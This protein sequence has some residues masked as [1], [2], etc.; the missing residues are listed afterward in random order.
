M[1]EI[2][3][4]RRQ[5]IRSTIGGAVL[6]GCGMNDAK[7]QDN[8]SQ[9][10]KYGVASGDPKPDGVV[11]WTAIDKNAYLPG[12]ELQVEIAENPAMQINKRTIAVQDFS[13]ERDYTAQIDVDGMAPDRL[14]YYRFS[15][16][17][18]HSRVGRCR[19][20]P[21]PHQNRR[22]L[23]LAVLTCQDYTTGY[24]SAYRHLAQNDDVDFAIHVGDFIYEYEE[25]PG[26]AD[27][28]V[29]RPGLS[30]KFALGLEDYR[31]IF[32]A[33]RLDPDLQNA[34]AKHTFMITIDDHEIGDNVHFN[35]RNNVR[36]VGYYDSDPHPYAVNPKDNPEFTP[37]QKQILKRLVAEAMQ[38]WQEYVP[39]RI[40]G[41]T[42]FR[43]NDT[44]ILYRDF[45]FGTLAHIYLTDSRS[46]RNRESCV[47]GGMFYNNFQ[48]WES[49]NKDRT[50]LGATQAKW[51]KDG[52]IATN[53]TWRIWG[54]QTLLS[55][56]AIRRPKI[57][58]FSRKK[59]NLQFYLNQDAWDGYQHERVNLLTSFY[60]AGIRDLVVLTGDMHV[61]LTSKVVLDYDLVAEDQ[62][63]VG[64]EFMT[65]AVSSPHMKDAL[66]TATSEYQ[67]LKDKLG[68]D[69]SNVSEMLL[70]HNTHFESLTPDINGYAV[71]ELTPETLTWKVYGFDKLQPNRGV[72]STSTAT[73][74]RTT[75]DGKTHLVK[76]S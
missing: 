8:G 64:L 47:D 43:G 51:L 62:Q 74:N 45:K 72:T 71:C 50:M 37:E 63:Q 16:N 67:W 9:I 2:R 75:K 5:V 11:L 56:C 42:D 21:A 60:D 54:N 28:I 41:R 12:L 73:Y 65:P 32:K 57:N 46:Y 24:F 6:A 4:T 69:I 59:G 61:G 39:A 23:N 26:F 55:E 20:L 38:A 27:A 44:P 1:A 48:C 58:P 25:Y 36:A 35:Y 33:F 22:Q 17:G 31:T 19:T 30:G 29:R 53:S 66:A 68:I 15:Y 14:Y 18:S 13:P 3:A 52:I 49:R 70:R 10:F 40:T 34:M 76:K 7:L